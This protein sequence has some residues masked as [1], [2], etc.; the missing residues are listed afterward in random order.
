MDPEQLSAFE[1][2]ARR[3]ASNEV[4]PMVGTEGRDG[5]LEALP[6]LFKTAVSVGLVASPNPDSPGHEYGVWGKACGEEGPGFSLILLREIAM[7]CAGVSAGIHFAGLGA[8][9]AFGMEDLPDRAAP[10]FFEDV[11]P[12]S[13]TAFETP[14]EGS[15]RI[16]QGERLS[17][18][19]GKSFVHCP[20]GCEGFIVYA[21]RE[22]KW[23]MVFLPV[24]VDGLRIETLD[25]RMGLA[26]LKVVH[27]SFQ[28]IDVDPRWLIPGADARGLLTR[29]MLGL[30]AIA[31]GNASGA[32]SEARRY[33]GDRFQGGRQ[34]E[35]HPAVRILIGEAASTI[36]TCALALNAAESMA[37]GPDEVL[38]RAFSLKLRVTTDCC[39]AV[40]DL[41]QVLGGYGYMED[42]R[43]EKRL[44]DAMTLKTMSIRPDDLRMLCS[45]GPGRSGP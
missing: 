43:L 18:T 34:I 29:Q 45:A 11:W 15:A 42:Y 40:S 10:A 16:V 2:T 37:G 8:K 27:L 39:R 28:D 17:L 30:S 19:G 23:Q 7:A 44:R 41:L 5:R 12:L 22:S 6:E 38:R 14:P 4:A 24:D 13:W 3:F 1:E 26:A 32:L 36:A 31:V 20:A 33:A 25:E 21:S 35:D 9:E